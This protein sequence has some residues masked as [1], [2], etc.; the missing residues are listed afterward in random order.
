MLKEYQRRACKRNAY[1]QCHTTTRM[2]A[3]IVR[4]CTNNNG[5]HTWEKSNRRF[6]LPINLL[7]ND[8]FKSARKAY[9]KKIN[10]DLNPQDWTRNHQFGFQ[11]THSTMPQCN[12][13]RDII[14]KDTENE[15]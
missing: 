10:K 15:Q 11:Q 4:D 2:L 1:I 14:N 12:R 6:I 5:T 3:Y 13:V 9:T 7:T 8:N